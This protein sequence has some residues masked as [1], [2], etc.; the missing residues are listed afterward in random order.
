MTTREHQHLDEEIDRRIALLAYCS[1]QGMTDGEAWASL[2]K[3]MAKSRTTAGR[4]K[5]KAEERELLIV[6]FAEWLCSPAELDDIREEAHHR[7]WLELE[8]YLIDLSDG[9]L[10]NLRVFYSGNETDPNKIKWD[11][12]IGK[13]AKNSAWYVLDLLRRSKNG[14][15]VGW[16]RT[17]ATM[18]DA[19]ALR[20][21]KSTEATP[22]GHKRIRIVP[23]VGTPSKSSSEEQ[24]KSSTK[25]AENLS[26]VLNGTTKGVLSLE[27]VNPVMPAGFG[28]EQRKVILQY[29]ENGDFSTIFGDL[30]DARNPD[31]YQRGMPLINAVDTLLT[32]AG[33]FHVEQNFVKEL[34]NRG[35]VSEKVLKRLTSGD[36]TGALVLREQLEN[37]NQAKA[38]FSEIAN[39]W[40]GI[41]LGHHQDIARR[42]ATSNDPQ[43]P[44]GVI[45]CALNRNKAGIALDLVRLKAVNQ[46]VVDRQL[47]GDLVRLM[48]DRKSQQPSR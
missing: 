28:D 35:G 46:L 7:P 18:I 32:S 5:E 20:A 19:V 13:F 34:V 26:A 31:E 36:I 24:E 40:I 42:I 43:G 21:A 29:F 6:A 41:Q 47:A 10:K 8:Q 2:P 27:G 16:G 15:A 4:D 38:K 1:A 23:T 17:V 30:D 12:Q 25:L 11:K 3:R 44:A 9:T 45:C 14:I 39:L 33:A 37:D 22:N 48:I